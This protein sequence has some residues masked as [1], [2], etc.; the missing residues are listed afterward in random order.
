[1]NRNRPVILALL[2]LA[3][4]VL[5]QNNLMN[6]DTP[7]APIQ[8]TE[9]HGFTNVLRLRNS[10]LDVVITPSV[11][12]VTALLFKDRNNMLHL[13]D[14]ALRRKASGEPLDGWQNYGG[15][16]FW[17]V[18][19]ERW[20]E[21][22]GRNWPPPAFLADDTW[23]GH[24]WLGADGTRHALLQRTYGE[25]LFLKATRHFMLEPDRPVVTVMQSLERTAE[26]KVPVTL[27]NI[28]QVRQVASAALPVDPDSRFPKGY[29]VL[30]FTEPPSELVTACDASVI[31]NV[32]AGTEHKLGSDSKRAW[33][34]LG[35]NSQPACCSR[36]IAEVP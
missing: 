23:Q 25:P 5:A 13:N 26:S 10:R 16:W 29:G 27:W 9:M 24:A 3:G 11:G 21:V 22:A 7:V 4:N 1:M 8:P 15:D 2:V 28:S 14:D 12:R 31:V 18:A 17:P 36:Y 35:V 34:G 20:T 33:I 32:G 30:A 6:R 19:Q